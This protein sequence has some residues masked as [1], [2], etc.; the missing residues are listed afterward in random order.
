MRIGLIVASFALAGCATSSQSDLGATAAA[1]GEPAARERSSASFADPL[2]SHAVP[3]EL[4]PKAA[5]DPHDRYH[6]S[7]IRA[8]VY[9]S[10]PTQGESADFALHKG[11]ALTMLRRQPGFSR[12]RAANGREGYVAT[13]QI[14]PVIPLPPEPAPVA[15]TAPSPFSDSLGFKPSALPVEKL[16]V[17]PMD[18]MLQTSE[19]ELPS[20]GMTSGTVATKP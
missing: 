3:V 13:D 14:I 5:T 19:P 4:Y 18:Q 9:T 8:P 6:V 7:A 12:V 1:T 2:A 17:V 20:G 11:D 15:P 16:Q 10:E